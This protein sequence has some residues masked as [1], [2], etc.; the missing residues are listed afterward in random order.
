MAMVDVDDA[1]PARSQ[2]ARVDGRLPCVIGPAMSERGAHRS[3]RRL[4]K[5]A[6]IVRRDAGD[7]AHGSDAPDG[8]TRRT[9]DQRPDGF[10]Q[11]AE[12]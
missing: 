10:D 9:G 11:D 5:A 8:P 2:Q 12:V 4:V 6:A 3:Q 1:E 7:A